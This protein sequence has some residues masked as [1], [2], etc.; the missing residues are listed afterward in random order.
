MLFNV[1]VLFNMWVVSYNES[2]K[3]FNHV[4][5]INILD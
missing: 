3:S 2:E 5:F 1:V 4:G